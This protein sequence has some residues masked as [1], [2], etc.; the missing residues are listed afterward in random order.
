MVDRGNRPRSPRS[1]RAALLLVAA[2]ALLLVCLSG[3]SLPQTAPSPGPPPGS[4]SAS[5]GASAADR[6]H[7]LRHMVHEETDSDEDAL[8]NAHAD[9]SAKSH[10]LPLRE[11]F[12]RLLHGGMREEYYGYGPSLP[13]VAVVIMG[14]P[15]TVVGAVESVLRHTD[16]NRLLVVVAVMDGHGG[17]GEEDGGTIW[18]SWM[19]WTVLSTSVF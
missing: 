3:G 14:E 12:R 9:A 11:R 10:G 8:F 19:S 1:R 5:G 13:R 2:A 18:T 6:Q 4:G 16:R 15:S 17:D 7:R